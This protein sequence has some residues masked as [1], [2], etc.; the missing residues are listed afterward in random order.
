MERMGERDLETFLAFVREIY[1][2][3]DLGNFA[4][5]VVS[6]LP[7]AIPSEWTSYNEVN[8]RSQ[9][10]TFVMEPLPSDFPEGEETFARHI[11]EHPIIRHHQETHDGRALKISDLLTQREFHR[12]GLYNEFFRRLEVE[13]QMAIV[14]PA[15]APL[16][17]GI[18]VNRNGKDFSE[19]DRLFLNLLRTHLIQAYRNAESIARLQQ[20]AAYLSR[21][22]E[23]LDRGV[24]VLSDETRVQLCTG[25]AREWLSEYFEPSRRG[26][27]LPGS[28]QRWVE[29]QR[30]LLSDNSDFPPPREPLIVGPS[31]RR[32]IVRLVEDSENRHLLLL[33]EKQAPFSAESLEPLG[34]THR[35]A[36]ILLWV[37]RGKTN[38]EIASALYI[39]PRTV[40][41]HLE[42]IYEKLG[43][44]NRAKATARAQEVLGLPHG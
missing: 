15:P 13:Y 36:E 40:K 25:K 27:K 21:A 4:Y 44:G 34:L 11:P 19:R 18:A 23:E 10:N 29:Q 42:H 6:L 28:L 30:S 24:I 1:A 8:L 7:K 16:V 31:G 22:L 2:A 39:S 35:E 26:D 38:E 37:T 12:L 14:L 33:L 41:K 43:V 32:L 9:T 17:I 3:P 5:K 20:D